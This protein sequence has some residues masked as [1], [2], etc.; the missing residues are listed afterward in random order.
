MEIELKSAEISEIDAILTLHAKYQIDTINEEDK[1]DGFVTTTFTKEQ[2]V[3]LI[4]KEKGLFIAKKDGEIVAYVMAASWDFWSAWPMFA[5][6]MEGLPD[7][8]YQGE[9]LTV[10]NSYQYGPVCI[11]KSVRGSGVLEQIFAFAKQHMAK[12]FPFLVTFVNTVNE[13]SYQA[14]KRKLGLDVV[15]QF[16]YNGKR[17]YEMVCRTRVVSR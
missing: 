8:E 14:H 17:Y 16:D 7:L 5:F 13:R 9:T 11:D 1:A 3:A 10:E 2:M 4:T 6:M 12:R 15:Q